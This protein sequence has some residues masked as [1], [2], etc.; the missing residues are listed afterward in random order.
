M[1]H[2]LKAIGQADIHVAGSD[3]LPRLLE[4]DA[5]GGAAAL[6]AVARLGAQAQVV[7]DH[8]AGHQLAGKMVGEVGGHRAI[9]DLDELAMGQSEVG[10]SIVICL[11]DQ[12][13]KGLVWAGFGK[14]ANST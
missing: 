2:R 12:R 4:A 14:L 8:D 3:G 9:H 13:G 7:L 6:D 5:A 1:A 11:F 10:N